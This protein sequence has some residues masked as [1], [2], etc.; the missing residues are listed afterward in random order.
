M[1]EAT[2]RRLA[3]VEDAARPPDQPTELKTTWSEKTFPDH[4]SLVE[5]T[6]ARER[7]NRGMR[8]SPTRINVT[9]VRLA[10]R[11]EAP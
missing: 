2:R 7:R 8:A 6:Q 9:V 10:G 11:G 5:W 1:N 4:A 3:A